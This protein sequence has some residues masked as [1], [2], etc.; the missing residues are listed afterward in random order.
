MDDF[1]FAAADD[2]RRRDEGDFHVFF[3]ALNQVTAA[4]QVKLVFDVLAMALDR[5]Y[6]QVQRM[7]YLAVAKA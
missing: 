7:R 1:L 3:G 4:T 6:T 2:V 5:F